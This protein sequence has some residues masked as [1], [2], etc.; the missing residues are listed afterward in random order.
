MYELLYKL[1]DSSKWL[2]FVVFS[3]IVPILVFTYVLPTASVES[4][5]IDG[6]ESTILTS[7]GGLTE[8]VGKLS[9]TVGEVSNKIDSGART[10]ASVAK[11]ASIT[12]VR[13]TGRALNFTG[14]GVS[15]TMAFIGK[16]TVKTLSFTASVAGN[17]AATMG[18]GIGSV[19]ALAT[20]S[21]YVT[22]N[23]V[24]KVFGN[25]MGLAAQATRIT[26]FIQPEDDTEIPTIESSIPSKA[27]AQETLPEEHV[28]E[29][30]NETQAV[31]NVVSTSGAK[32]PINGRITTFFG[33]PHWPWQSTHTGMDISDGQPSG[34]TPVYPYR[35]GRVVSVVFSNKGLGNHVVV[36]HGDG[37]TSLYGHLHSISVNTG[38]MVDGNTELGREGTTGASTGTHLHLEIR[39]NGQL[40]DPRQYIPGSP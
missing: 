5:S 37:I 18:R 9:D 13:A 16:S 38:Q 29:E 28:H 10:T 34:V 19:T 14:R 36:D 15:H 6:K 40:V 12:T 3:I 17:S 24:F 8:N 4:R 20:N 2:L 35:P 27:I 26:T 11:S 31:A 30:H 7:S 1:L 21:I 23:S 22:A 25:T 39:V 32:W 33:V